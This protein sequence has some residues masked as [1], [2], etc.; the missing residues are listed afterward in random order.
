VRL[1]RRNIPAPAHDRRSAIPDACATRMVEA[2]AAHST[3][4]RGGCFFVRCPR[5]KDAETETPARPRS[6]VGAVHDP[7]ASAGHRGYRRRPRSLVRC[8]SLHARTDALRRLPVRRRDPEYPR[9]PSRA[10]AST[11]KQRRPH[12]GKAQVS[13]GSPTLVQ[14]VTRESA[15]VG[16]VETGRYTPCRSKPMN[17]E[18]AAMNFPLVLVVLTTSVLNESF[19]AQSIVPG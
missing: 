9:Y 12:E 17:R 6:S 4:L 8:A 15:S 5:G 16:L 1:S 19:T 7:P 13:P 14:I 2:V 10:T 3:P 11:R 18:N